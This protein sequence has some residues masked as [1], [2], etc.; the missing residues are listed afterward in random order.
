[1]EELHALFGACRGKTRITEAVPAKICESQRP[2]M[3]HRVA[4]PGIMM[5]LKCALAT[6]KCRF[7]AVLCGARAP[8]P[9]NAVASAQIA[10]PVHACKHAGAACG[11]GRKGRCTGAEQ[12]PGSARLGRGVRV[13]P[14]LALRP[15]CR[16]G[17][18]LPG[19]QHGHGLGLRL[20][21]HPDAVLQPA[22]ARPCEQRLP[23]WHPTHSYSSEACVVSRRK[24]MRWAQRQVRG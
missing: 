10:K 21:Q 14:V 5:L 18:P 12:P 4:A 20:A 11:A 22:A 2:A 6:Q 15:A 9:S 19:H 1:M 3:F 8:A 7:H 23:C 17:G 13:K 24:C 16:P